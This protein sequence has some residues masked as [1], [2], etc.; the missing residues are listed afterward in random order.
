MKKF[1]ILLFAIMMV[2]SL[3]AQIDSFDDS[4][5]FVVEQENLVFDKFN[6]LVPY[7]GTLIPYD[8]DQ[9]GNMPFNICKNIIGEQVYLK[10]TQT[11]NYILARNNEGLILQKIQPNTYYTVKDIL[12]TYEELDSLY[13]IFKNL[14]YQYRGDTLCYNKNTTIVIFDVKSKKVSKA[15]IPKENV[16][17]SLAEDSPYE[18]WLTR[19]KYIEQEKEALEYYRKYNVK[20]DV[21]AYNAIYILADEKGNEYYVSLNNSS[22]LGFRD[23]VTKDVK[24]G[25]GKLIGISSFLA[26]KGYNNIKSKF[27][28]QYVR[29]YFGREVFICKKIA[30]KDGD[31]VAALTDTLSTTVS[32]IPVKDIYMTSVGGYGSTDSLISARM[33]VTSPYNSNYKE[34]VDYYTIHD[35]DSIKNKKAYEEHLAEIEKAK[36]DEKRKQELIKKYGQKYGTSIFNKEACVGMTKA[37]CKE[38]IGSP[39]QVTKSQ[40]SSGNVEV[41]S[42]TLA[43]QMWNGLAPIIVVTFT[44]DRVTAIDKYTSWPF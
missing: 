16:L 15:I 22:Y 34:D 27:E 18:T 30:L 14:P 40:T 12:I 9:G 44:N 35:I 3:S 19:D 41:W 25:G 32:Y 1:S 2:S 17:R 6:Y 39:D 13:N 11:N 5:N 4:D 33:I 10:E 38:A 29:E 20:E 26:V 36:K 43:Y 21:Y 28:N 23:V 8:L 42:Y 31:V 7:Q 37:M 24:Y